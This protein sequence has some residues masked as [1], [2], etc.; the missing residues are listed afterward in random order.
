[1]HICDILN[2]TAEDETRGVF[3]H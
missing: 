1:M 3:R 2:F